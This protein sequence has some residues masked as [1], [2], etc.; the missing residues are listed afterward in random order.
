MIE[1]P[2]TRAI[3]YAFGQLAYMQYMMKTPR[4]S[5]LPALIRLN[6]HNAIYHNACLLGFP[7]KGMCND[8]LL[9][10]FNALGPAQ[11]LE[12]TAWE[13]SPEN[14]HPTDI[15]RSLKHHPWADLLPL[16]RLRDNI[17]IASENGTIDEDDLCCDLMEVSR[18]ASKVDAHLIVWGE[19]WNVEMWEA[20]EGFL[21][22]WGGLLK[23]C[24]ELI[25]A[26]NRWREK[27]GERK[28]VIRV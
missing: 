1:D 9:S 22:K 14:L 16:P 21:R 19:S 5:Y 11:P 24:T 7:I 8:D 23:G 2:R 20:S 4:L 27:R 10:P 12:R 15:Q 25:D 3:V 18:D 6:A 28:I 13:S 17:L 26:T